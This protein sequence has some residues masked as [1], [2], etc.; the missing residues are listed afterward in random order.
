MPTVRTQRTVDSVLS[1]SKVIHMDKA[2]TLLEPSAAPLVTMLTK[3]AKKSVDNPTFYH[4]E[5]ELVPRRVVFTE[6]D[7]A[8]QTDPKV[9]STHGG[10]FV[11]QDCLFVPRTKEI[12]LITGESSGTLTALRGQGGTTA[13]AIVAGDEG[14]IIPS[15][16]E[17]DATAPTARMALEVLKTFYTQIMRDTCQVTKSATATKMYHGNDRLWQQKCKMIEHKIKMEML[18]LFG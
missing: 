11:A 3:A 2:I 6:D 12:M 9:S 7:A 8:D 5:Q 18:A 10:Y 16:F 14:I 15:S 13:K 17:E 4:R 1:Q